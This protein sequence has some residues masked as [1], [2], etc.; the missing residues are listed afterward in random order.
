MFE[1]VVAEKYPPQVGAN[2]FRY[3]IYTFSPGYENY[4]F[5]DMLDL[6]DPERTNL[7]DQNGNPVMG[8][9]G[10]MSSRTK[11]FEIVD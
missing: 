7:R 6:S 2:K 9:F 1:S 3:D 11:Y 8:G 4:Y 5:Y 10:V